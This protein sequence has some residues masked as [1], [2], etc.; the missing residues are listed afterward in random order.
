[1]LKTTNETDDTNEQQ[2]K[3][4][5]KIELKNLGEQAVVKQNMWSLSSSS[6]LSV[7]FPMTSVL[8]FLGFF[9]FN[10]VLAAVSGATLMVMKTICDLSY[11]KG[12][13]W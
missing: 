10:M 2:N 3:A 4:R 6:L 12:L 8:S 9:F 7:F 1:M 11:E 13:S 5:M